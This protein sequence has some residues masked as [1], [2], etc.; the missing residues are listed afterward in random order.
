MAPR[1]NAK[2]ETE[3]V[4]ETQTPANTEVHVGDLVYDRSILDTVYTGTQ[5][6]GFGSVNA[7]AATKLVELGLITV[8]P[9]GAGEDGNIQAVTTDKGNEAYTFNHS[10]EGQAEAADP[11][12]KKARRK[13]D[14][15]PAEASVSSV[16]VPIPAPGKRGR[17]GEKYPF[18]SLEP[19]GPKNSFH[20]PAKDD[21]G[22]DLTDSQFTDLVSRLTSSVSTANNRDVYKDKGIKFIARAVGENDHDGKGVRVW[23][24]AA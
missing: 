23:R 3:T 12:A 20:I 24:T 21:K 8:N 22:V 14:F 6:E 17:T 4:T 2:K 5:A 7:E 10:A 1:K 15:N 11:V 18:A 19:S 16:E 13:S 9:A